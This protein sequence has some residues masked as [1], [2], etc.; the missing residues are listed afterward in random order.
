MVPFPK[1]QEPGEEPLAQPNEAEEPDGLF[2]LAA[3]D[4]SAPPHL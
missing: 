3:P 4:D 2:I 1:F